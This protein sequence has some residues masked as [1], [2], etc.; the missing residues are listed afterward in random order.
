VP[1]AYSLRYSWR[2]DCPVAPSDL[3]RVWVNHWGLDGTVHRG[4]VVVNRDIVNGVVGIFSDLYAARFPVAKMWTLDAFRGSLATSRDADSTIGYY[5]LRTSSGV[6]D[7]HVYGR[8]IDLNPVQNPI[9]I[10]TNVVPPN[11][12]AYLDRTVV[13]PGMAVAG[14]PAVAAFS[15]RG[16]QWSGSAAGSRDYQRMRFRAVPR[17][18]AARVEPVTAAALRYSYRPGCPVAPSSLRRLVV[19]HWGFDGTVQRGELIARADAVN[20]L[21]RVFARAYAARFPIK[22]MHRVDLYRGSDI[23]SMAADNTSAFNCRKVTGNPYRLSQHSYGN[24][25]DINPFENPYV[26]GSRYYPAGSGTYLRRT[27]VRPGMITSRSAIA[28]GFRQEG[29]PWGAR[30]SRPDYQHFSSNG[31]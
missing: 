22:M 14:G 20:D 1:T 18:I 23:R 6:W 9:V 17:T 3:R 8:M 27:T 13:R 25:I 5:C 31:G 15:A 28:A 24:A 2:A 26:T 4:A 29:W 21:A 19:N 11:G 12:S 10:G 16:W 7:P 30:W